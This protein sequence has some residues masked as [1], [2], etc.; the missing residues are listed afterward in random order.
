MLVPVPY[1]RLSCLKGHP[2]NK[3]NAAVSITQL[4]VMLDDH[5]VDNVHTF[6]VTNGYVKRYMTL[7]KGITSMRLKGVVTVF[8]EKP[9]VPTTN[10]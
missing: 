4:I 6:D 9:D 7:P 3:P 1:K 5:I 2:F 8:M 10:A